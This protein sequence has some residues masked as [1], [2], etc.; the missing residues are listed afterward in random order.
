MDQVAIV[1]V[2]TTVT[3]RS[4]I[5]SSSSDPYAGESFIVEVA[6]G[7]LHASRCVFM[8][9]FDWTAFTAF[10]ADLAASWK[11]WPGERGW[12][13]VEGDLSIAATHDARGHCSLSVTVQDGANPSWTVTVGEVRID[14]GEDLANLASQVAGWVEHAQP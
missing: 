2:P 11:G 3:F 10:F 12:R 8:F 14:A 4:A 9:G 1:D 6:N 7:E 13:S 5:R